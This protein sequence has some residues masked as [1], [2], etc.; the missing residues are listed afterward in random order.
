MPDSICHI[1]IPSRNLLES[2]DFYGSLFGWSFV[3]NVESYLLFNDG[4]QGFGGGF[5]TT[6]EPSPQGGPVIFIKVDN[7]EHRLAMARQLGAEIKTERQ[8]IGNEDTGFGWWASF[9]D[10]HGNQVGLF[11]TNEREGH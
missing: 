9:L 8:H 2:Q 10:P 7:L 6:R 5:T 4:E 11:S 3:P 1:N